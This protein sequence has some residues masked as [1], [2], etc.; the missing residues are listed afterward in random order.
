MLRLL[1]PLMT[2]I[3]LLPNE[4]WAERI[5]VAVASNFLTTARDITAIFEAE[6]GHDVDLV[7]GSTG[8]LFAQIVAGAP[9]DIYLAAD[10]ERP[11]RLVERGMAEGGQTYHYATGHLAL[12]HRD[13]L[14][15]GTIDDILIRPGLRVALADPEVAPYGK[16]AREVLRG[17]RGGSWE[18]GLVKGESV[19]QAFAF[20]AT[21][22]ADAGLIAL[23]QVLTYEGEI[24]A[25]EVDPVLHEPI[26]QDAVILPRAENSEAAQEFISFLLGEKAAEILLNTGYELPQ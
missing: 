10:D 7:H 18:I 2:V 1:I 26:R 17:L 16:A 24:W 22:N 12:I 5:T 9:F 19:G 23:S 11:A 25:L 14:E 8:K 20:V 6:T 21:G 13:T 3:S 4:T 15:P